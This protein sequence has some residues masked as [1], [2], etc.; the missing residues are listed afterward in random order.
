MEEIMLEKKQI[1]EICLE[2]YYYPRY[3]SVAKSY[4]GTREEI[5]RL[6]AHLAKDPWTAMRYRQTI[7]AVENYD[8]DDQA[9]HWVAGQEYPILIP[10]Q[11]I[12]RFE[13]TLSDHKWNYKSYNGSVVACC[14][15][16]IHVC[17][18][19]IQDDLGYER[20]LSASTEN[21]GICPHYP[22]WCHVNG[23][24][25]GFPGIVTWDGEHSHRMTLST[26]QVH[27]APDQL[28]QA[29]ADL[30]DPDCIDL[31]LLM[32]DIFGEV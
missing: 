30:V 15:E 14:A 21:L 27:Y 31:S 26:T 10:A 2:N 24:I 17:Q 4:Y 29:R 20:C 22:G 8:Q 3:A 25:R 18:L 9:T 23:I 13:T 6:M 19:L 16:Q 7:E 12:C 5:D 11:E 32:A 28:E 1:Y